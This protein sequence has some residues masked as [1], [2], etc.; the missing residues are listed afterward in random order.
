M[1]RYIESN[2]IVVWPEA[3]E[4]SMELFKYEDAL[5]KSRYSIVDEKQKDAW[6]VVSGQFRVFKALKFELKLELKLE[7]KWFEASERKLELK[8]FVE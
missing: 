4:F 6:N 7:L 1:I 2:S 5:N 3:W 8:W